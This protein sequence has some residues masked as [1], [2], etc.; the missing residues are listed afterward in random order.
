MFNQS[1]LVS[2]QDAVYQ[3]NDLTQLQK[4]KA[5]KICK[6]V[7]NQYSIDDTDYWQFKQFACN[8]FY[9][10][11]PTKRDYNLKHVLV[12]NNIFDCIDSYCFTKSKK[13]GKAKEFRFNSEFFKLKDITSTDKTFTYLQNSNKSTISYYCPH[14]QNPDEYSKFSGDLQHYFEQ[15]MNKLAFDNDVDDFIAT[16][17]AVDNTSLILNNEIVKD[18]FDINWDG[19]VYRYPKHNAIVDAQSAG[20]NLINYKDKYYIDTPESFIEK[21]V[22]QLRIAYCKSVF[23]I[24]S[25]RFYSGRNETNYRFDSN[26]TGLKKDLFQKA[27]FDGERLT[28]LD[29]ANAQFAIAAY[30]NPSLDYD[31]IWNAQNGTLYRY[32]GEHL[33]ISRDEAKQLMFRVAFD[34]VKYTPEFNSLRKLFPKFMYWVDAYKREYGYKMFSNLLQ[35]KESEIMIDG[36]LMQLMSKGYEVFTVHDALRV[37]QSQKEVIKQLVLAYFDSIGFKSFVR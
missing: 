16:I 35:R 3:I 34:K 11:V 20:K 1:I 30:L 29:I 31:F 22:P 13:N 19:K 5:A 8:F 9:S 23:N 33:N 24:K 2:I 25:K 27:I 14:Y 21:K 36:L 7:F 37:K 28:E 15:N 32:V 18:H 26:L 4:E 10:I 6:G 17:A 12:N